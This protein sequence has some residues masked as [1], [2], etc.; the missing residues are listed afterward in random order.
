MREEV[1]RQH[2]VTYRVVERRET[3]PHDPDEKVNQFELS[4]SYGPIRAHFKN[5]PGWYGGYQRWLMQARIPESYDIYLSHAVLRAVLAATI[6]GVII[7]VGGIGLSFQSTALI[8]LQAIILGGG[9]FGALVGGITLMGMLVYPWYL[10]GKRRDEMDKF[11]PHAVVFMHALSQ[12]D[13]NPVDIIGDVADY[14]QIYGELASEFEMIRKDVVVLNDDLLQAITNAQTAI[15]SR[16]LRDFLDDLSGLL[17]SGGNIETFLAH[18]VETQLEASEDDLEEFT[19]RLGTIAPLFVV[20]VSVGPV[21]LLVVLLV[22][23]LMGSN[24]VPLLFLMTYVIIPALIIGS[25]VAIDEMMDSYRLPSAGDLRTGNSKIGENQRKIADGWFEQYHTAKRRRMR[26][27]RIIAPLYKMDEQPLNTLI[28]TVPLSIVVIAVGL[29]SGILPMD[30]AS[31][32]QDPFISTVGY[33]VVPWFI[34]TVPIMIVYEKNAKSHR[35]FQSRFPDALR[36]LAS[37]NERG[38]PLNEAI[39]LIASRFDGMV[40]TEFQRTHRDI[41]LTNNTRTALSNLASRQQDQRI[42]MTVEVIRKIIGASR[43]I[44]TSL[45]T[46][47]EHLEIRFA[48]ERHRREEMKLYAVIV[49]M[50]ILVYLLIIGVL[51]TYLFTQVV[52]FENGGKNSFG[53]E[54]P[55]KTFDLIFVHS[56]LILALGSGL[57]LGKLVA[58]SLQNGLKYMNGLTVVVVLAF[59]LFRVL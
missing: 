20:L 25:V 56:A 6:T 53:G 16:E 44:D 51:D 12:I 39:E 33:F 50:G 3:T 15:P 19:E 45:R 46:L 10:A 17:E 22:M 48:M 11:L 59:A 52:D 37:S 36:S 31:S 30:L 1:T 29:I 4:S 57:I 34:L 40:S 43:N 28:V 18:E 24:V 47:A 8:G 58:D 41:Q 54:L 14:H 49:S 38:M 27:N 21:I 13:P 35:S 42:H 26:R 9:L 32:M 5:R 7:I 23:G 2:D 55:L